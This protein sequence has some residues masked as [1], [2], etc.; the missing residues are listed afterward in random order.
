MTVVKLVDR[1]G[2]V[3]RTLSYSVRHLCQSKVFR[4]LVEL[5]WKT[6]RSVALQLMNVLCDSAVV[7]NNC[8]ASD[9]LNFKPPAG[10]SE[11]LETGPEGL[12]HPGKDFEP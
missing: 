11:V 4:F 5:W 6:I 3:N 8:S 2:K 12:A 7:I 1:L 9:K 10:L